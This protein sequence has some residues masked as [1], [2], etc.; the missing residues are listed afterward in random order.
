MN[1]KIAESEKEMK[2][3]QNIIRKLLKGKSPKDSSHNESTK[4][5][6]KNQNEMLKAKFEEYKILLEVKEN[7]IPM[8]DKLQD[9]C[10]KT[11]FCTYFKNA[12]FSG[13]VKN[14]AKQIVDDQ[15]VISETFYAVAGINELAI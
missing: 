3:I 5:E 15:A 8:I 2:V 11:T 7:K 9:E 10:P 4:T 12:I 14:K 13:D 1:R 6:Y